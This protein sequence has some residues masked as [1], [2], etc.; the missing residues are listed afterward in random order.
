[1]KLE[2][3]FGETKSI[4]HKIN[5][6]DLF[7]GAGGLTSGL[8]KAGIDVRIGIDLDPACEF[9]YSANNEADF[10][11][12]S[13]DLLNGEELS[14]NF[15]CG[16]LRLL[17]GCAPCQTFSTY[18]RKTDKLDTRWYLLLEFSRVS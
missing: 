12:K 2:R 7:C 10:L 8:K 1:M 9:P 4:R 3:E 18:N 13:V 17:A 16:S 5:A 6:I 11:L 15:E 14:K